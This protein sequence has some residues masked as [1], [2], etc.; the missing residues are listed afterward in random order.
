MITIAKYLES[1][2]YLVKPF[3]LKPE[4]YASMQRYNDVY[5][6]MIYFEGEASKVVL[7]RLNN[8]LNTI[9]TAATDSDDFKKYVLYAGHYPTLWTYLNKMGLSSVTCLETAAKNKEDDANCMGKPVYSSSLVL[10]VVTRSDS[11]ND[12]FV[13]VIYNG[14]DVTGKLDCAKDF[15][16]PLDSF[17]SKYVEKDLFATEDDY[18]RQCKN[19]DI[20]LSNKLIALAVACIIFGVIMLLVFIKLLRQ[21]LKD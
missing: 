18:D 13:K 11:G 20:H 9:M 1:M 17:L 8:E 4:D 5:E 12:R 21:K 14:N 15:Y 6:S 3:D 19:Y 2:K 7:Y 10:K 16:C